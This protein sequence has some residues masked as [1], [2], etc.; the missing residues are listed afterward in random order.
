[1]KHEEY[2]FGV[3]EIGDHIIVGEIKE[4]F[5]VTFDVVSQIVEVANEEFNGEP[6]AYISNRVHSFSTQ[7]IL[8]MDLT[9]IK[10]NLIAF[11]VVAEKELTKRNAQF[12]E[13][14]IGSDYQ[15]KSFGKLDTAVSWVKMVLD[16]D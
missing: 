1:M 6:W 10:H 4:G 13:T 9:K 14:F 8:H 5:D 2:D 11:A 16:R 12:E 3:L 15:F 7:P